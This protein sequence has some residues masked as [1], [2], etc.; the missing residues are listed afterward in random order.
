[1]ST[2]ERYNDDIS[3]HYID[4]IVIYNKIFINQTKIEK[5][6]TI[7]QSFLLEKRNHIY[8]LFIHYFVETNTSLPIR[9]VVFEVYLPKNL[10]EFYKRAIDGFH[11][12][13]WKF[14]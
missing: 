9:K 4:C 6:C 3:Y 5:Q 14:N 11:K 1:M 13:K 7:F 12:M 8:M 10:A 2:M